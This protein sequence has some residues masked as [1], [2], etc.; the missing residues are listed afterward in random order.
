MIYGK[1]RGKSP[2]SLYGNYT[3]ILTKKY[4]VLHFLLRN[5]SEIQA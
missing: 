5:F 4:F 1:R 2:G 3:V